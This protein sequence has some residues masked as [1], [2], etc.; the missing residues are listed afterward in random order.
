[1]CVFERAGVCVRA[2]CSRCAYLFS[3]VGLGQCDLL[4]LVS[5]PS[6]AHWLSSVCMRVAVVSVSVCDVL[7]TLGAF[8]K[9]T[10]SEIIIGAVFG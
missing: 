8:V 2:H 4:T 9:C 7:F 1:M 6:Y 3:S 5:M 10:L